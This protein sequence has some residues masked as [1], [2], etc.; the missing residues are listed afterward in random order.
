MTPPIHSIWLLPKTEDET[1]LA[2]VVAELS[3]RFGTPLFAPH[4]TVKGDTDLPIA[5]LEAAIAEAAGA[6]AGFAE[7]IA[8]IETSEAYFRS[9]YARFAV[10]APLARLKQ[11]LDARAAEAFMPHVSLLYGPVAPELKV[12]AAEE[13]ARRLKG[14]AIS[15]DRLCVVRSGQDIPI[16]DWRVIATARLG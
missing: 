1:L 2:E 9:F 16:A 5:A 10:S 13:V 14:R 12:A 15:F 3:R 11:R 7:E 6:V 8:A 4:L